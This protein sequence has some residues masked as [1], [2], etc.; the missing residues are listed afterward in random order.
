MI[1]SKHKLMASKRMV[2]HCTLPNRKK[3][4]P[5]GLLFL[6]MIQCDYY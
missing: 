3:R 6:E 1:W 2:D 4:Y 5:S